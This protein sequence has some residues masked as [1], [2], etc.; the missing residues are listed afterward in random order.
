MQHRLVYTKPNGSVVICQPSAN[1]I[2]WMGSGGRWDDMPRGFVDEQI[3]R[4]IAAGHD[5][6]ASVKFV[7]AMAFGGCTEAEALAIIRDRDC[8]HL[9]TGIELWDV[10]EVPTDRWFRNAWVRSPNGGPIGINLPRAK[11]IHFGWI[12]DALKIENARR[13]RN[14]IDLDPV[15]LDIGR[16]KQTIRD[17]KELEAVRAIWPLE[18]KGCSPFAGVTQ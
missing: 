5:K 11:S 18:L 12:N 6:Y 16:V 13:A 9:G 2:R 1:C 7:R 15:E 4:N 3:E 8:A 10:S 14:E 17:A